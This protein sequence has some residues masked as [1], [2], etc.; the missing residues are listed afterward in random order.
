MRKFERLEKL[1]TKEKT[2]LLHNKSVLVLGCGGVGGYVIESLARSGIGKLII[3]DGDVV[4]E[5]NLNRQIIALESTIGRKKVDVFKDRLKD[6]NKDIEV[7]TISKFID[8][9]NIDELFEYD[10]DYFVDACDTMNTKK[11]VIKNCIDK[12]IN[13]ISSMGTGNRMNPSKL[14]ITTLDKTNNDPIARILRK[15]VKEE[16]INKKV[17]VL[18]STEVPKKVDGVGSNSFVPCSAGLLITSYIIK[19]LIKD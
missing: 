6:I 17:R 8:D 19:E 3:V 1:I 4:E 12:S 15:Y 11:L 18:C 16:R 7:I 10:I 14:E 9:T 5:T 13:L 2:D